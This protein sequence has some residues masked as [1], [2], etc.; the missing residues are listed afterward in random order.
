VLIRQFRIGAYAVDWKD[1]WLIE[2]IAGMVEPGETTEAVARRE[3]LEET[4]LEVG[5]IKHVCQYFVSPGG[6]T[7][8][9]DLYCVEVDAGNA[10]AIAG[11]H[12]EGEDIQTLVMS[13]DEALALMAENRIINAVT[14]I[15]LQ[16][17]ALNRDSLRAAWR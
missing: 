8:F 17:L 14:L 4:G 10:S 15:A 3:T 16:W 5:R 9:V 13:V 1:P 11:H 6:A 12:A 7:E 2:T